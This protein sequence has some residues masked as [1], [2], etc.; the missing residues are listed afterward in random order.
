MA[1]QIK[2]AITQRRQN[3]V[4]TV[5][6]GKLTVRSEG[7]KG[8]T[9]IVNITQGVIEQLRASGL[10]DGTITLFVTHTTAG[11]AVIEDERGH[12]LDQANFWERIIPT[13]DGYQ[14]NA[15]AGDHNGHSHLRAGIQGQSVVIPFSEGKLALGT[16]QRIFLLE[17]DAPR[18]R[19]VIA[20]IMGV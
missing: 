17:F 12:K 10:T 2:S 9:D 16:Y 19:T 8:G 20:Q 3:G 5:V 1:V 15:I 14:H 11:I 6:S 13:R 18:E 4:M 7:P